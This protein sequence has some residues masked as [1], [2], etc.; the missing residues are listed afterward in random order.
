[1]AIAVDG[2]G[3]EPACSPFEMSRAIAAE[4]SKRR[5]SAPTWTTAGVAGGGISAAAAGGGVVGLAAAAG[6]GI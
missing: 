4:A 1:M 3:S 2:R 6:A 5:P